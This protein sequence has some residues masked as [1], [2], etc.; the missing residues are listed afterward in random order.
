MQSVIKFKVTQQVVTKYAN[1]I[2]DYN[3]IHTDP[4]FASNTKFGKTIAHGMFGVGFLQQIMPKDLLITRFEV[5]FKKPIFMEQTIKGSLTFNQPEKFREIYQK[6]QINF[7]F[8]LMG[9]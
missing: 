5:K 6:D 8:H 7:Y 2:G 4:Q 1:I 3:P 9:N